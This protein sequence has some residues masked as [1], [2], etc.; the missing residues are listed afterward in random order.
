MNVPWQTSK[1]KVSC[2]TVFSALRSGYASKAEHAA[3][4]GSSCAFKDSHARTD[5]QVCERQTAA[6]VVGATFIHCG[7]LVTNEKLNPRLNSGQWR[8]AMHFVESLPKA[9]LLMPSSPGGVNKW[10]SRANSLPAMC[11]CV[12]TCLCM[13][14]CVCALLPP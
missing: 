12:C 5:L 2:T 9:R 13:C 10:C 14:V 7:W 1:P 4:T 3:S 6:A 11:V 8:A